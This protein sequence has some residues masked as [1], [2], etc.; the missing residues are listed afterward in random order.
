MGVRGGV[1]LAL[2]VLCL[3]FNHVEMCFLTFECR[4]I[5]ELN[6][7]RIHYRETANSVFALKVN[8][9]PSMHGS[10]VISYATDIHSLCTIHIYIVVCGYAES[11]ATAVSP[12]DF[13]PQ[14]ARG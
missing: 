13:Q 6:C 8:V 3:A 4:Y 12:V 2:I 10:P 14:T 7:Y 5:A 11:L 1:R 9:I